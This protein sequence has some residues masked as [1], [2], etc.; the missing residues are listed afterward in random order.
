MFPSINSFS[1]LCLHSLVKDNYPDLTTFSV[2][3]EKERRPVVC[4][5]RTVAE[6]ALENN[7][8]ISAMPQVQSA[9]AAEQEEQLPASVESSKVTASETLSNGQKSK[10][11][12]RPD[13]A[14]YVPPGASRRLGAGAA[15]IQPP[16]QV[17][18]FVK[19]EFSSEKH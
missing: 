17:C 6:Y 19:F 4:H 18:V 9:P 11:K 12:K 16:P 1:R 14:V 2:G 8:Q 10:T 7:L 13:R 15:Q 5:Q 3:A